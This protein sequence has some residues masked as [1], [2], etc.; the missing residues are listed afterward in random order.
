MDNIDKIEQ[1]EKI[2]EQFE[3]D[4]M[5]KIYTEC[6]VKEDNIECCVCLEFNW[7]VKLP[8]CNHYICSKCYYKIYYHG[9][10]EDYFYTN[11]PKP[12]RIE[13]INEPTYP[14]QNNTQ[15]LE[16][17]NNLTRED[18]YK[19]WFINH[20]KELYE[21]IKNNNEDFINIDIKLKQW[22]ETDEKIKMYENELMKYDIDYKDYLI[23][24]EKW[25]IY[26][27]KYNIL[28]ENHRK[29]NCKKSCPL[30]RK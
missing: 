7:G 17:Y 19:E 2:I 22:F 18:T 21:C 29:T 24:Y 11:N 28:L 15:N 13:K 14:Y 26:I 25:S 23:K 30:C 8:N 27:K 12:I 10:V 1:L 4:T 16:L 6:M 9:Y 20:N 3:I 5:S